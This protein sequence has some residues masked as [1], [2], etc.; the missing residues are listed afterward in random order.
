MA[1]IATLIASPARQQHL[2]NWLRIAQLVIVPFLF[3]IL[4]LVARQIDQGGS[5]GICIE[6]GALSFAGQSMGLK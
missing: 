2:V 3:F 6:G 1:D 4:I 5:V